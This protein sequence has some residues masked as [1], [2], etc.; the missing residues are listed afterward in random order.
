MINVRLASGDKG[1]DVYTF[2]KGADGTQSI[3]VLT[4]NVKGWTLEIP[5]T[6]IVE[7]SS[8]MRQIQELAEALAKV[9]QFVETDG[10]NKSGVKMLP[11]RNLPQI[12]TVG[13]AE[14]SAPEAKPAK[15]K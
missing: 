8:D 4:R 7:S 2:E 5:K 6:T 13:T 9:S 15:K 14:K 1:A 12:N 11:P 3:L 10:F